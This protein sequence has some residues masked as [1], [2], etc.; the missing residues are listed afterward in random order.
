MGLRRI[1]RVYFKSFTIILNK[2]V[3]SELIEIHVGEELYEDWDKI[4]NNRVIISSIRRAW[5]E[6]ETLKWNCV[7]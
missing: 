6:K 7:S 4:A 1:T 2:A 5:T 3:W